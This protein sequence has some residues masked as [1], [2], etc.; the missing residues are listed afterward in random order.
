MIVVCDTSPLNYLV[1]IRQANLLP[2]ATLQ[3]T[4]FREPKELVDELLKSQRRRSFG[5]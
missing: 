3:Q 5:P 2:V 4:S 1:L